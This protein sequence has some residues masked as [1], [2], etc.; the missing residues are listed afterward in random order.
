MSRRATYREAH[1]L[2]FVIN[3]W[4]NLVCMVLLI[5]TGF[6]IHYPFLPYM[7]GIVRGLHIFSAVVFFINAVV[8]VLLS[9][10]VRSAQYEGTRKGLDRDIKNFL[11]SKANRHQFWPWIKYYLF[12]KK[13]HPK[14]TKYGSPQKIAYAALPILILLSALTGFSLWS[15]TADYALF[16]WF[17]DL[18]GGP[19]NVRM[20]H[21]VLMWIFIIFIFVHV[22]LANIYGSSASKMMF[23]RKEHGGEVIDPETLE[24][25]GED[26]LSEPPVLPPDR[27]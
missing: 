11:P 10:V 9:F 12:I 19:M 8:R 13:E 24:V 23:F 26:D 7:M 17:T 16:A 2:P 15:V 6:C 21:Y 27:R 25:I 20:L 5:F 4:I 18:L 1:P 14:G 22:Y 3:H